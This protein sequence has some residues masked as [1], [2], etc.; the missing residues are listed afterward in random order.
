M[1]APT[2]P[3]GV[4]SG[5][6][7]VTCS[8]AR[9]AW[10]APRRRSS[11]SPRR[12]PARS[13]IRAPW[14]STGPRP[15]RPY[16]PPPT[17]F[18]TPFR[19]TPGVLH[20]VDQRKLPDVL[21]EY[22]RPDGLGDGLRDPGD[23][24]ARR[25]GHRPGRGD[26]ADAHGGEGPD[27]ASVRAPRDAPWCGEDAHQ[28]TPDRGQPALGGRAGHGR[29]RGGRRPVRGRRCHRR[30]DAR[31]GGHDRLRDDRG[32]RSPGDVRPGGTDV[33]GGPAVADP[34]ALQYR[35]PGMRPVRDRPRRRPGRTPRR[36]GRARLGRRD[37]TVPA[38]RAADRLGAGPGRR[39]AHADPGRGRRSPDGERRGGRHPRRG[40]PDR[41]QRRHGQQGRDVHAGRAGGSAR[42][43]VLLRGTDQHGGP[44][45]AR[46]CVD[47]DRGAQGERGPVRARREHRPAGHRGP[48][49]RLRRDPVRPHHRH[50]Q[51]RGRDPGP[52][53]G[54]PRR[55][56]RASRA[57]AQVGAG[58]RGR[59]GGG[60]C[61]RRAG[62]RVRRAASRAAESE[63]PAPPPTPAAVES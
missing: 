16:P 18:R 54:G 46:R 41:R 15:Y 42:H 14:R 52:V 23:D 31:R 9:R 45:H 24:R 40:R 34:H 22:Q 8:T 33:P 13:S 37:P 39:S 6:S 7:P 47:P 27:H 36:A 29:V 62:R 56:R 21:E 57:A 48:Q 26:R 61:A 30:R 50:R 25:T 2:W 38:G 49:S 43:P 32:S 60:R 59:V 5:S 63:E 17:G 53:P 58:V 11:A 19:E 20:L 35:A 12:P 4:S 44:R 51:R 3:G 55:G 28:R 1:R 10:S